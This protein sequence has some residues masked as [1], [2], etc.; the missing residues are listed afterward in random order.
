MNIIL[1]MIPIALALMIVAGIVF[2]WAANHG[3][4][5]DLSS[6]GLLP[7]SDNLP[8]DDEDDGDDSVENRDEDAQTY[9]DNDR[10]NE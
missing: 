8:D 10:L 5:E 4:F 7:M 6:P 9:Q 1:V 2:F 3:Q